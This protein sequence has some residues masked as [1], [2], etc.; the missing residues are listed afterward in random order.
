[1]TRSESTAEKWVGFLVL[2]FLLGI[3]LASW[4]GQR[5]P[6]TG[7]IT[8]NASIILGR[9]IA[10]HDAIQKGIVIATA[11]GSGLE[12]VDVELLTQSDEPIQVCI[13]AGTRFLSDGSVQNMVA[14]RSISR[15]LER[16][17]TSKVS[18]LAGCMNMHRDEPGPAHLLTIEAPI[19]ESDLQRLITHPEFPIAPFRTQQFAI[20]TVTDNPSTYVGIGGFGF[21]SGPTDAELKDIKRL[22]D[23]AAIDSTKFIAFGGARPQTK[24]PISNPPIVIPS[25][26][27]A[28]ETPTRE[29]EVAVAN[30]EV[31]ANAVGA[32]LSRVRLQL[33]SHAERD[34]NIVVPAGIQFHS[35]GSVQNMVVAKAASILLKKDQTESRSIDAHCMNMKRNEPQGTDR[36]MVKFPP[37]HDPL[38]RLVAVPNFQQ[39]NPKRRQ[40]AVWTLTDNPGRNQFVGITTS[41]FGIG[42]GVTPTTEDIAA[43]REMFILAKIDPRRFAA[44]EDHAPTVQA[45]GAAKADSSKSSRAANRLTES[46]HAPGAL[47]EPVS[48]RHQALGFGPSGEIKA[49]V[50]FSARPTEAQIVRVAWE[51]APRWPSRVHFYLPGQSVVGQPWARVE[52]SRANQIQVQLGP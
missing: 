17:V 15:S 6:R 7:A 12:N 42:N 5:Y 2:L 11:R 30:Q 24:P 37:H 14:R 45:S 9:S 47:E 21:G 16:G 26:P 50:W 41:Q 29:L 44:L 49:R 27:P 23:D 40:F 46:K 38:V 51:I 36:L 48:W 3:P 4:Y 10:L 32:G 25:P 18:V 28:V 52:R 13:P 1:M 33:I 8:S 39:A 43:I 35:D 34:L 22:L 31:T 19:E 20:W